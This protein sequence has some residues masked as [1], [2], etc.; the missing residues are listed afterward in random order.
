MASPSAASAIDAPATLVFLHA[1]PDD[2]ALFTSGTMARAAAEGHRVILIVA[3]SGD[4]GLAAGSYGTGSELAAVRL[5]ELAASARAL[6]V[7]RTVLLGYGDSGLL[8][9]AP[10]VE[11]QAVP[12]VRA[13][14]DEAAQRVADVL[15]DENADVI[16]TYD[17][18]GGYGHPDHRMVH[19]VGARAAELAD[20]PVVL[21]ATVPRDTIAR[22]VR[23]A[24]RVY[25]F[26]PQF[27]PTTFE[28]AFTP[29]AEITHRV[30]VTDYLDAKRESMAAHVSQSTADGSERTLA[31][32][33][34]LPRPIY[35]L[36]FR[37]EWYV[38]RPLGTGVPP[39]LFTPVR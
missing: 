33:M 2:E 15:R 5:E 19:S 39:S 10:V 29:R 11:D 3:T 6:G 27:D 20:T 26:P 7:T 32:F 25:R 14:L 1:H 9:D 37:R 13:N 38:Q 30:N 34:R 17:P 4:Q 35:R 24:T 8:G 22:A 23:L 12:F 18:A 16:T 28:R 31:A 21:E 36:A